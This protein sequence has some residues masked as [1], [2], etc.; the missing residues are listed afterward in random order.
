MRTFLYLLLFFYLRFANVA[1]ADDVILFVS[2][3]GIANQVNSTDLGAYQ[4]GQERVMATLRKTIDYT[5]DKKTKIIEIRV[6]DI[7]QISN[8]IAAKVN[9]SDKVKLAVFFGH[10]NYK[11]IVFDYA[12][13]IQGEALAEIFSDIRILSKLSSDMG[14]YFPACRCG[15][16]PRS[17]EKSFQEKFTEK[18]LE[19]AEQK[20][21]D[22]NFFHSI[23]HPNLY[24]GFAYTPGLGYLSLLIQK[25]G[26]FTLYQKLLLA[27]ERLPGRW[28]EVFA[29]LTT[30]FN[31]GGLAVLT[32]VGLGF[33][34]G[35]DT[36]IEK[37]VAYSPMFAVLVLNQLEL[38]QVGVV[39]NLIYKNGKLIKNERA[40]R[41]SLRNMIKEKSRM[42][43]CKEVYLNL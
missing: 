18:F 4:A 36:Q 16:S 25:T 6:A 13:R 41:P 19:L 34:Y 42:N 14:V 38:M 28:S 17:N 27:G 10:G 29:A 26:F 40:L 37:L 24:N 3:D 21:K 31:R 32:T 35:M 2:T 7:R 20:G 23:A 5:A 1:H 33:A 22:S 11:E 12:N 8:E 39:K 30:G 43:S 9:S 15:L